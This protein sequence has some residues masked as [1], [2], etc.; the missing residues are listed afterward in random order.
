M[1]QNPK[2]RRYTWKKPGDTGRYQIDHIL[3]KYSYRNRVNSCRSSSGADID[4]DYK[5]VIENTNV[6]LIK[7]KRGENVEK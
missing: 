5:M 2:I 1:V 7:K 6:T 4:S 3:T